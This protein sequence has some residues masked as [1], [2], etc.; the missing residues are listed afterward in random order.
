MGLAHVGGVG[1][2]GDEDQFYV[3]QQFRSGAPSTPFKRGM[4]MSSRMRS[5]HNRTVAFQ[6]GAAVLHCAHDFATLFD[7][8]AEAFQNQVIICQQ[9]SRGVVA[10]RKP[11]RREREWTGACLSEGWSRW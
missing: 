3:G 5:G 2:H 7:D 11:P 9:H 10:I 6:Q 4:E 8:A 1:V